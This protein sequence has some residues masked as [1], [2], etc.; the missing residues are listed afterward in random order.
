VVE[1][2]ARRF[3]VVRMEGQRIAQVR[4]DPIVEG[5]SARNMAVVDVV[6]TPVETQH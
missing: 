3:M 4:V 2:N 5:E 1:F 6:G